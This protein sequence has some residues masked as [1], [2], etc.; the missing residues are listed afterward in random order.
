MLTRPGHEGVTHDLAGPEVLSVRVRRRI[1]PKK[2]GPEAWLEDGAS[3][4]TLNCS[5]AN[6]SG[7]AANKRLP[8]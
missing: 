1:S 3:L 7:I 5:D 2:G 6:S 8:A 4:L